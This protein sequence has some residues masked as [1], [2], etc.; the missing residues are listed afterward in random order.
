M[1]AILYSTSAF[2]VHSGWQ[3]ASSSSSSRGGGRT[4]DSLSS[5]RHQHTTKRS[6]HKN[7]GPISSEAPTGAVHRCGTIQRWDCSADCHRRVKP[8]ENTI[9]CYKCHI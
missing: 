1:C 4:P 3:E 7:D 6:A 2:L 9:S 5:I 8:G